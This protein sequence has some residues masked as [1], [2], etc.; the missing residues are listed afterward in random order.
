MLETKPYN[1]AKKIITY[2][3]GLLLLVFVFGGGYFLGIWQQAHI[4]PLAEIKRI[5]NKS[6]TSDVAS[7]VDFNL[8]W[9][10]WEKI[11]Q[12]SYYQ[13]VDETRMYYGAMSGLAASVNDPYTV[14]FDPDT[15][16][17]FSDEINGQI[18]GVGLE[19]G[20]KNNILTVIAPIAN[21]PAAHAGIE[22]GDNI[23]AINKLDT[24]G[25]QVDYAVSLI[26]GEVDT[27]VELTIKKA[28]TGEFKDITLTRALIKV[29]SVD[30]KMLGELGYLKISHFNSDTDVLFNTAVAEVLQQNPKGIILDLRNNPGG[31][32]DKAIDIAS[33]FI[34]SGIVVIEKNAAN[35]EKKYYAQGDARLKGLP[36]I[37]LVNQGSASAAE[38]VAG[39]LKDYK[40]G[41][42]VG[43]T[44]FGKG[45]VQ[46]LIPFAD[47]SSLKIT[48]AEWLTPLGTSIDK[49]GIV[50]DEVVSLSEEDYNNDR[51]P[52]L[53]RAQELLK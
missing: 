35:E 2:S 17:K 44:T 43:E 45:V 9:D 46:D 32:L 6:T 31:Y 22:A 18:Y 25:M 33:E 15:N 8:F 36:L 1:S 34:D 3:A 49:I 26:R 40:L 42:V 19:L 21:T 38:I 27:N 39:A 5:I 13:P 16:Q 12:K 23:V 20:I 51:D 11:K 4:T 14:Y 29:D 7:G 10:A 37:V 47:G 28:S 24:S 30:A 41:T 48:V 50:P 52:Q 53:E